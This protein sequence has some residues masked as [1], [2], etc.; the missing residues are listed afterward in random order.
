MG[1]LPRMARAVLPRSLHA[2]DD[3]R[4]AATQLRAMLA[5]EHDDRERLVLQ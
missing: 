4:D 3:T 1:S 2:A 5:A